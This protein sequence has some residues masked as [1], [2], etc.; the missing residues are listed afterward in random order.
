MEG[1]FNAGLALDGIDIAV[2]ITDLE[3][4]IVYL[5]PRSAEV[6]AGGDASKLLGE[7]VRDC[8]SARSNAIIE[9][10]MAGETNVYT[11]SKKG[12]RKLIYQSPWRVGGE[13]KGLIE[14]SI[15]IPEDMPH[16]DRG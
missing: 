3:G 4:R 9:R 13:V 12:Q 2:T 7:Q 5:N 10:L 15:V 11:I 14:F 1:L 16:Y 8:H 6:N